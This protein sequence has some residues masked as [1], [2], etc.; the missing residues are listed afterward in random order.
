MALGKAGRTMKKP[1]SVK[2]GNSRGIYK[3]QCFLRRARRHFEVKIKAY[4]GCQFEY[5]GQPFRRTGNRVGVAPSRSF[6]HR[7]MVLFIPLPSP[8]EPA[9]TSLPGS[10]SIGLGEE[11]QMIDIELFITSER[12]DFGVN[13]ILVPEN[14]EILLLENTD[15]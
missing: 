2:M 11:Y 8:S 9:G 7:K 10:L 15:A 14:T 12:G 1:T 5:R 13:K 3:F 4:H 6:R